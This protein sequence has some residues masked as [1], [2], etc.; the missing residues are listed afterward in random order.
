MSQTGND[1][2]TRYHHNNNKSVVGLCVCY[3]LLQVAPS[4]SPPICGYLLC[5]T[6]AVALVAIAVSER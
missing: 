1:N 5:P 2:F 4:R 6:L 3:Q